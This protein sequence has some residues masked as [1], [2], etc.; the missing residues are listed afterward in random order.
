MAK[1]KHA[2]NEKTLLKGEVR[3]LTALRRAYPVNADTHYM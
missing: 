1:T 2:I 3:K